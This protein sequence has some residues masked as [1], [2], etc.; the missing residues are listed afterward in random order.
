M[1]SETLNTILGEI[2]A[3]VE[4]MTE[5]IELDAYDNREDVCFTHE[6]HGFLIEGA[7]VVGGEWREYGDGY[8]EPVEYALHRGWGR[9]TELLVTQ[10][11]DETGEET[12]IPEE[13]ITELRVRLEKELNEHMRHYTE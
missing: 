11:D 12:E 6:A 7:G 3:I 2:E 1:K 8:W 13:D 10:I 9:I 5:S 4:T